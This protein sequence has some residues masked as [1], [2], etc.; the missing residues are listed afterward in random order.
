MELTTQYNN[1]TDHRCESLVSYSLKYCKMK[2]SILSCSLTCHMRL[3]TL[4][5]HIAKDFFKLPR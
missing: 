4:L 2:C 5:A 1:S 3:C